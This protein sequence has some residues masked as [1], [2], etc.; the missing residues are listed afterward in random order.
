M[1]K[2][3]GWVN[4]K[5]PENILKITDYQRING[6]VILMYQYSEHEFKQFIYEIDKKKIRW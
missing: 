1:N 2:M 3:I 4:E 5:T 6:P